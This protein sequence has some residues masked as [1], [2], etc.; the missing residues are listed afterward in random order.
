MLHGA[1]MD[2]NFWQAQL[3][4]IGARYLVIVPDLPAHGASRPYSGFTLGTA[5]EEVMRILDHEQVGKAHVVGQSMGG[6][7]A[8]L[9]ARGYPERIRSF[10][11]VDGS[12]M[13]RSYYSL[14]DRMLL[15]LTPGILAL[16]PERK[17]IKTIARGVA[18]TKVGRTY[19]AK[20]LRSYSKL[21]IAG[22]MATIEHDLR[23]YR[24]QCFELRC[25]GFIVYGEQ[26]DAGKV[27]DYSK[28]W[29]AKAGLPLQSIPAAG[30]NSNMD[31]PESF[32]RS[33]LNFLDGLGPCDGH[34]RRADRK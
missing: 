16:Y 32:N 5:A 13:D 24:G 29:A 33:L 34:A 22:I 12:P 25:P 14:V 15:R 4:A 20:V 21:E 30:H 2:Q 27:I 28:R 31:N 19:A 7:I 1:T 9:L 6:Y 10:T 17:L 8:Q 23:G 11:V 26:D 18:V 3:E